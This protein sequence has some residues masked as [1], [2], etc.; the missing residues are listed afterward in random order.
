MK[1]NVQERK[2]VERLRALLMIFAT[3]LITNRR[4]SREHVTGPR[5]QTVTSNEHNAM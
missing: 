4:T 5:L 1:K 2:H 3:T